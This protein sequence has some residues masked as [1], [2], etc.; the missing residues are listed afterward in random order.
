MFPAELR[1]DPAV[2]GKLWI[3]QGVGV[4]HTQSTT[5]PFKL[6]DWSAGIEELCAVAAVAVPGGKTFLTAWDKPF[7][8]VDDP[9]SYANDFRYPVV[10]GKEHNPNLVAF[11]SYIDY[12]A[13]DPRFLVGVVAPSETSAPGYSANGG[14]S[15]QAFQGTP[16][17]GWG[18]GGCVAASTKDNIVLLPSNNGVGVF[19][20]DG[21]RNWSSIRLDG[22]TPTGGFANAYYV[23]RKNIAADKMRAGTFALVYT[24]IKN[25]EF[26]EPLGGVWVTK[27]GGESWTQTLVG[28]INNGDHRPQAAGS[29]GQDNRQF[30]QCQLEY[31]PGRAG[32]LVYTPHADYSGDRLWWSQDDGKKWQELHPSVRNVTSFGFGK[33][34]PGRPYP[35]VFFWGEVKKVLGLYASMDWFATPPRLLTRFPSQM[36]AKVSHVSG[37]PN[38]FGTVY[39]GTSCAGW[40]RVDFS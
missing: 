31:V 32:E 29:Q 39:V 10:A 25:N 9:T 20:K 36:L 38:R 22:R 13:N 40:V 18:Y 27:D 2:P 8:R 28:V 3:A 7:W 35:T 11:G 34:G 37:D 33:A 6:V 24:V 1:F 16:A 23:A 15:W 4:A 17:T 5:G 14:D 26:G 19:T 30:W 12:A 21:G